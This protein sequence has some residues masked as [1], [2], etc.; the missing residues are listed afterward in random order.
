MGIKRENRLTKTWKCRGLGCGRIFR[1]EKAC[2]SHVMECERFSRPWP[3]AVKSLKG[4]P[5]ESGDEINGDVD[6]K[7]ETEL[8]Y[9]PVLYQHYQELK[10]IQKQFQ[11]LSHSR[12]PVSKSQSSLHC[13]KEYKETSGVEVVSSMQAGSLSRTSELA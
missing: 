9:M 13:S 3:N 4:Y 1:T 12:A 11:I 7:D 6:I 5:G 8:V 2:Y 10:K